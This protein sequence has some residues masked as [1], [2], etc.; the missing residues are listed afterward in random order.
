MDKVKSKVKDKDKDN[1]KCRMLIRIL[2][3][4]RNCFKILYKIRNN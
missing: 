1:I 4:Y 2:R 3:E